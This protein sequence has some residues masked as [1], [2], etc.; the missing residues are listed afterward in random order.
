MR[1]LLV[2]RG[3]IA[4]ET[5]EVYQRCGWRLPHVIVSSKEWI[6]ELQRAAPWIADVPSPH[7]HYVQEY[8]DVEAILGIAAEHDIDAIYPGY[9][10]LAESAAF[11]ER[12]E[13]TGMRFI[14][15]TPEALRAV[16]D[17]DSA[18]ALARQ[19]DIPTIPG[20]DTLIAYARTHGQAAIAAETV[21]RTVAMARDYPGYP[22]RLKHP[23]G[24][25]GKGQRVLRPDDVQ[26][27]AAETAI[28]DALT[29]L[30]A[31]MGVSSADADPLKGVLLELN[32][33]RPLHWEVQIFG[34]GKTVVQFAARDCSLQNQGYQ[35]FIELALHPQAIAAEIQALDAQIDAVRIASLQQRQATLERICADAL[36]LGQAIQLRGAATVEFLI[37]EQG[38][39]YFLEV[40]PR[41][42]VEHAV[43]EGIAR[44]RGQAVSLVELQQ[45]VA[46]GERLDFQQSDMTCVGDA[47]EV[48][49]NAWHED[50][51]P[52]LGGVVE[53]FRFAPPCE[54]QCPVRIDASGLLDRRTPWIVPSYDANFALIIVSGP[55]RRDTLDGLVTVLETALQVQGNA[56]LHT[57]LYPM[58]GLLTLMRALPPET[59]FR[60]DTSL[61]WMAL[62]AVVTAQ[63]SSVLSR[64]PTFP[65]QAAP[66]ESARFARLTGEVIE[67]GF[68]R[69]SRLLTFY[70]KRLIQSETRPLAPLEVIWQLAEALGVPQR[71][72]ERQ[73]G[74]ALRQAIDALWTALGC[75]NER[76]NTFCHLP[77]EQV[78]DS[79]EGKV[80]R[81]RLMASD[82][83]LTPDTAMDLLQ[84]LMGWLRTS[85]PAVQVLVDNL[86]RTQLHTLLTPNDDLSLER[87][88]YLGNI[89]IV[90][91]LHHLLSRAL[92][93]TV[94]RQGELLSPME[95]TIYHQPEPGTPSFVEIGAEISVGQTLALLEAMK[96]FTELPSPVEGVVVDILVEN[97]QG[98]KTG[99]PLFK[100]VTQDEDAEMAA[101]AMPQLMD[102]EVRNCFRLV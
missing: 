52:V 51:S 24:G 26:G 12:V 38:E 37:D 87:P 27:D 69:P 99:E 18:I 11:A 7:V 2:C 82:P 35:K 31:E 53:S 73:Q 55:T 45:R 1:T 54:F 93:P 62:V 14:G 67:A 58:L 84:H 39:P 91:R 68:A 9:G 57:N 88:A 101:D 6:A 28:L 74:V 49:L 102:I 77:E 59:E 25:G 43:T 13:Q 79:A 66:Y 76:F 63:K 15:P 32:I 60:T 100:I 86:E 23:A 89:D 70:I 64:L 85:V 22:I 3:P 65:R 33:P 95:A 17:K 94:L 20:D 46:A 96:M 19:L 44:V 41:I 90:A 50:L 42:Q 61:L 98:V 48:R 72:E 83:Q 36:R 47:I 56:E 81:H 16:G 97:G 10:F 21:R 4:F 8:N 78:A 40:N 30:W 29:K 92:R 5:L 71:E 80:V 34:D 75:S